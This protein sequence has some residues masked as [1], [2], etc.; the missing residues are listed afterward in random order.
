MK[1]KYF[2]ESHDMAKQQIMKWLI[3]KE[4]W[5]AHPM[6]YH[7]RENPLLIHAFLE[8][9]EAT[10]DVD[11][12]ENESPDRRAFLA[13]ATACPR[14]LLL[15]PDTGLWT[16]ARGGYPKKHVTIEEFLEI[17]TNTG[18]KDKLTLIYDQSYQRNDLDIWT[19]TVGKLLRLYRSGIHAVAYTAHAGSNVRFIWAS[20]SNKLITQATRRMQEECRFPR[21]RFVDDGCGHLDNGG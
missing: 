15:D 13:A 14:H 12:V 8:R 1:P 6:W 11:I 21:W 7:Q 3:P 19:Q 9:Y 4:K 17:V 2:G 5:A 10:L 16:P 20:K 18:R